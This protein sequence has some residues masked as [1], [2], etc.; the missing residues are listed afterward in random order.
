VQKAAF[1]QL[2]A[3]MEDAL[4][5]AQGDKD[6]GVEHKVPAIPDVAAIRK[7]LNLSQSQFATAF[8]L[9]KSSIQ[10]WEQGRRRPDRAARVLLRVIELN[11]ALVREAVQT[12]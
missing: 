12:G 5:Y 1:E 7:N 11:P 10:E 8:G 2:M 6:R 4:A 9:D 3:G